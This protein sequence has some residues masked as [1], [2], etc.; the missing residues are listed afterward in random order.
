MLFATLTRGAWRSVGVAAS[1]YFAAQFVEAGGNAVALRVGLPGTPVNAATAVVGLLTAALSGFV[2]DR[3]RPHAVVPL[4][5]MNVATVLA[6]MVLVPESAPLWYQLV[7]LIGSPLV[8]AGG[9][10][11]GRRTGRCR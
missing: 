4:V 8:T 2:V 1:A 6:L 11:V 5:A 9:G 10:A 7:F 3:V